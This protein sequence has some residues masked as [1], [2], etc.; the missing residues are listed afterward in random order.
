MKHTDLQLIGTEQEALPV[1][2]QMVVL[3]SG[4]VCI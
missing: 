4:K 2:H 3:V 1:A